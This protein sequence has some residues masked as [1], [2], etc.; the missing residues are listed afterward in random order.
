[1][2]LLEGRGIQDVVIMGVHANR[3][4]LGRPYGIRQ[5]CTGENGLCSVEI[6]QTRTI[7]IVAAISGATNR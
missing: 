7:A 3:C 4:V 5:W 2:A 1:L 6:S